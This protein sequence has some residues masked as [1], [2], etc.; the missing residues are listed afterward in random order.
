[1]EFLELD[2]PARVGGDR[3]LLVAHSQTGL[4]RGL[5]HG[6]TLVLR[7]ADGELHAVRVVDMSFELT[8]TVYTLEVGARLPEDLARER[9]AGLDAAVH[10]L[11]L[12]EVVDLL[13]QLARRDDLP[14]D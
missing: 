2:A 10:D 9:V 6:E 8:D 4:R 1:M 12:H 5:D 11:A 13:G 14:K 7:T 3:E